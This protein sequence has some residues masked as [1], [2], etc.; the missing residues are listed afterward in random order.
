[1]TEINWDLE[2]E[3]RLHPENFEEPVDDEESE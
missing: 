3:K 2:Q 1:M